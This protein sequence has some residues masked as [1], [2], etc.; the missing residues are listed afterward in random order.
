MPIPEEEK[1]PE[2]E[3]LIK[4]FGEHVYPDLDGERPWNPEKDSKKP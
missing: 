4:D 1:G 3:D 2:G